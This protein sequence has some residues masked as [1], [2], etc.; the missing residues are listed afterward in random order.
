MFAIIVFSGTG[1]YGNPFTCKNKPVF[2][3]YGKKAGRLS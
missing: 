1:I 2:T 3:Y